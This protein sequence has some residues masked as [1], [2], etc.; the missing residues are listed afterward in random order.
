MHTVHSNAMYVQFSCAC[1]HSVHQFMHFV[2]IYAMYMYVCSMYDSAHYVFVWSTQI[3]IGSACMYAVHMYLCNVCIYVYAA[4]V[5]V[6]NASVCLCCMCSAFIC[7]WCECM[8]SMCMH[9]WCM[10]ICMKYVHVDIVPTYACRVHVWMMMCVGR[11]AMCADVRNVQVVCKYICVPRERA[12]L[13][14]AC[15][16][17][18]N[19][20]IFHWMHRCNLIRRRER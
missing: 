10:L 20:C 4:H 8:C 3:C 15:S 6:H 13:I 18:R 7:M 16:Y 5:F 19:V 11:H 12:W 17:V 9:V 2:Y 1:V 14:Y